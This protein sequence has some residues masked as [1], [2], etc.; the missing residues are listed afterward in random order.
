VLAECGEQG[1]RGALIISAG[2]RELGPEGEQ[3]E[4][5]LREVAARFDGMR[6]LGPNC[7]GYMSPH[8]GLN[9]SFVDQMPAKGNVAFV[10]QS[11]A[12]CSSVLDWAA[13]QNIGFSYFVSFGN[14]MDVGVADLLDYL[15]TD[16]HTQSMVL[17]VE[18][19][20]HAR[21][22]MS[23]A[24][25]FAREKPIIAYKVRRVGQGGRVA[26]RGDGWG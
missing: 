18:S 13:Q 7:L 6:I 9:V 22:F 17:Y 10:S 26:H 21:R 20:N 23:A 14:A 16:P 19:I 8:L 1:I 5:Q 11:G 24:R 3:L 25:A 12:L 4:A 15:A 2:F